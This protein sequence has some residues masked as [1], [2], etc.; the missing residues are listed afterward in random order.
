MLPAGSRE[1]AVSE[2]GPLVLIDETSPPMVLIADGAGS[3]EEK[4]RE[5]RSRAEIDRVDC[6]DPAGR[7]SCGGAE[8]A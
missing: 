3:A 1:L 2:H 6:G 7:S 5:A 4:D 8:E